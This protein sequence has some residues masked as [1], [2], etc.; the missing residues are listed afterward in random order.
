MSALWSAWA[1]LT[2]HICPWVVSSLNWAFCCLL[3]H[4]HPQPGCCGLG[5]YSLPA[6][7]LETC[8]LSPP[9][10]LKVQSYCWPPAPSHPIPLPLSAILGGVLGSPR[11][12]PR[13]LCSWPS[14]TDS[15]NCSSLPL[16]LHRNI[17]ASN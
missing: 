7:F 11:A 8:C 9:L 14:S 15:A 17:I 6:A 1:S 2:S 3:H 10:P 12:S 5:P 16:P 13:F 4:S